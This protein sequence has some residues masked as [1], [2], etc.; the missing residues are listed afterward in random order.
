MLGGTLQNGR[1]HGCQLLFVELGGAASLRN[2]AQRINAT[3][4]EKL[5]PCV[6]GLAGYAHSSA[7][8]AQPLPASSSR[9]ALTR[10]LV[11][12]LNPVLAMTAFSNIATGDITVDSINGCHDL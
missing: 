3:L 6:H 7:T 11:A 8:S 12:S 1:T 10:F 9:P 5:F 4:I 2:L